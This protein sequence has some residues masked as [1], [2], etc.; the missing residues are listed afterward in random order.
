MIHTGTRSVV[1]PLAARSIKSF[2]IGGKSFWKFLLIFNKLCEK[3]L[4]V[5]WSIQY[6][7]RKYPH[8]STWT[9]YLVYE[10]S[11][12][13]TLTQW[14]DL[15]RL[16]DV[17]NRTDYDIAM[18]GGKIVLGWKMA[19]RLL[20]KTSKSLVSRR[21]NVAIRCLASEAGGATMPLTFGSPRTVN[22]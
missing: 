15:F 7:Q 14:F 1:S 19:T 12:S 20:R 8:E 2:F 22:T 5:K 18:H 13:V 17:K 10:L 3:C 11:A 21:F 4:S 9:N 16:L 6:K